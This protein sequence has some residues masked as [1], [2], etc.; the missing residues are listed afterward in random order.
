[1]E[2][3]KLVVAMSF[4][5]I[6]NAGFIKLSVLLLY[7]RLFLSSSYLRT[8]IDV[9]IILTLGWMISMSVTNFLLCIPLQA[10]WQ[11]FYS[12]EQTCL[13]ELPYFVSFSITDLVLDLAIYVLPLPRAMA[14]NLAHREKWVVVGLF[15]FGILFVHIFIPIKPSTDSCSTM[16]AAA[17]RLP[18]LLRASQTYDVTCKCDPYLSKC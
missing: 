2:A 13:E 5:A 11:V 17:A 3:R 10:Y 12:G 7:R 1:M 6:L 18:L 4:F 8:I 16:A 15:G 9:L 14:L